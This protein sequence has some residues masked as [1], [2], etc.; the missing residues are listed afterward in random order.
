MRLW[1]YADWSRHWRRRWKCG[2]MGMSTSSSTAPWKCPMPAH[3]RKDIMLIP[4]AVGGCA[5]VAAV[6][7]AA[8]VVVPT[9]V[10]R[11]LT[12]AVAVGVLSALM[13]D[14]RAWLAVTS[15]GAVTF[16]LA[17]GDSE[18]RWPFLVIVGLAA[19]LGRGQRWIRRPT[20]SGSSLSAA[21]G[22]S[23]P[24]GRLP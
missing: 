10:G 3:K 20:E 9:T 8:T 16:L 18:N 17:T 21:D 1:T 6:G 2:A 23:G 12:V 5:A 19:V 11:L 13:P 14:P 22:H 4:A 24:A 15:I 7:L